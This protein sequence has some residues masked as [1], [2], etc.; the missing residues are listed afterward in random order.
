MA[1]LWFRSQRMANSCNLHYLDISATTT[2]N[3]DH[4]IRLKPNPHFVQKSATK[5]QRY[6]KK[7]IPIYYMPPMLLKK[8]CNRCRKNYV[9]CSKRQGYVLCF[10]CQKP[11]L[12]VEIED[13]EMKKL[14]DIPEIMYRE[15][16][17]LCELKSKY[18]RFG[19]LSEKQV[20][21][22]L[23]IVG[24]L[25]ESLNDEEKKPI[26]VKEIELTDRAY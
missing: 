25:S 26:D 10:D 23:K 7:P 22:F 12:E 18:I 15:N 6:L 3:W 1:N 5:T 2:C 24:E 20:E 21:V 4:I 17:F 11:Q 19:S 16:A 8:K 13:P 9:K 14:F